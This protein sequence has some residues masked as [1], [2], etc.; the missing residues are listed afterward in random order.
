MTTDS[1]S[2]YIPG[3]GKQPAGPFTAEQLIQ[4]WRAGKISDKTMCWQDGMPQWLPLGQV[5]PLVKVMSLGTAKPRQNALVAF[6]R[7]I[8][9]AAFLI[10]LGV[11]GYCC[12][13]WSTAPRYEGKDTHYWKAEAR[14]D[15]PEKREKSAEALAGLREVRALKELIRDKNADVSRMAMRALLTMGQEAIPTLTELLSDK[16]TNVRAIAAGGLGEVGGNAAIPALAE[17]AAD[18]DA[19]VRASVANAMRSMGPGA[20][21][22]LA[23]LLN[24]K[25]GHVR[26]AAVDSLRW[27]SSEFKAAIPALIRGLHDRKDY[28]QGAASEGLLHIGAPAVAALTEELN[29]QDTEVRERAFGALEAMQRHGEI[30]EAIPAVIGALK[31]SHWRVRWL[32]A[33]ALCEIPSSVMCPEHK[34]AIP[35]LTEALRDDE[36]HVRMT[37]AKALGGMRPEAKSAMPAL[38]ELLHDP[39]PDVQAAAK[40]ALEELAK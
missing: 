38:T 11:I 24:D 33:N 27:R 30:K 26:S 19:D 17:L 7:L 13:K 36:L 25:D 6:W 15:S 12:L 1:P 16:N 29:A 23:Q 22:T 39:S 28:V 9:L 20:I 10:T 14:S 37:A 31:N 5:G 18:E 4:S 35:V 3:E 40:S 32:A 34:K 8:V 21:P 2:W